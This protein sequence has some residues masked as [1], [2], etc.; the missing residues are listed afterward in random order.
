MKV[1]LLIGFM[2]A[3][4]LILFLALRSEFRGSLEGKLERLEDRMA[5]L[6]ERLDS[7]PARSSEAPPKTPAEFLQQMEDACTRISNLAMAPVEQIKEIEN[8]DRI[9]A[10][11]EKLGADALAAI[12]SSFRKGGTL[13][14]RRRLLRLLGR[15]DPKRGFEASEAAF[16]GE[17][18]E[19]NL[20]WAA[21]G[22]MKDL[23]REEAARVLC[24]FLLEHDGSAHP[25]MSYVVDIVKEIGSF[26]VQETLLRIALDPEKDLSVRYSAVT[27]LGDL[28]VKEAVPYLQQIVETATNNYLRIHA[29]RA[30]V[31]I[32]A[33]GNCPFL[34]N[35]EAGERAAEY[36][37]FLV[38]LIRDRC[39]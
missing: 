6:E 5:L 29:A 1:P 24:Q 3:S 36:K 27:G 23:D 10:R 16:L 9:A 39:P 13:E 26:E 18:E 28:K 33:P 4:S 2:L 21:A 38:Q 19:P 34:K 31:L 14:Y 12:E 15:I 35:A 7:L 30:L 11:I 20:R 22:V 25:G 32:D 17:G 8:A 37:A